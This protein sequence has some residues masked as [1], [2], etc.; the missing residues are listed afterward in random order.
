MATAENPNPEGDAR[1]PARTAPTSSGPTYSF[2]PWPR[3]YIARVALHQGHGHDVGELQRALKQFRRQIDDGWT[4]A[5][6]RGR[7]AKRAD[8]ATLK[9]LLNRRRRERAKVRVMRT[10]RREV[11]RGCEVSPRTRCR[12]S[13]RA[14][15]VIGSSLA[16]RRVMARLDG[17]RVLVVDDVKDIRDVFTQLLAADGAEVM[18]AATGGEAVEIAKKGDFDVLITDLK[19]PDI[20]GDLVIRHVTATARR[21]PLV[22]VVTGEGEPF[23]SA[24]RAAGADLVLTKPIAWI[25]LIKRLVPLLPRG[26]SRDLI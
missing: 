9:R 3:P 19:L 16:L 18:A 26:E 12:T 22:V 17:V 2:T 8:R 20:N 6:K 10:E 13:T 23:L 24:A 5:L 4:Y 11:A 1:A 25:D 21:R 14:R 15:L 7:I